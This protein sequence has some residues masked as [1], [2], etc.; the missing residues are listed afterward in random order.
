MRTYIS[1]TS[2]T[3]QK[4]NLALRDVLADKL[5]HLFVRLKV[6]LSIREV[7]LALCQVFLF[8]SDARLHFGVCVLYSAQ[9]LSDMR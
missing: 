2:P 7:A 6:L 5:R 1:N 4:A 8:F 3:K 9:K